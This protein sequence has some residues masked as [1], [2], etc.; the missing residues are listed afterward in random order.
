MFRPRR[1]RF[2]AAFGP[3]L[4][5]A[6]S[7]GLANSQDEKVKLANIPQALAGTW[8]VESVL[9]DLGSSRRLLYQRDD[10]RLLGN[11]FTI[12]SLK[13]VSDTPEARECLMP[14]AAEWKTTAS[15][16]VATT[17]A[18]HGI[19]GS[20]P[21]VKD[22]GLPLAPDAQVDAYSVK[23]DPGRFGPVPLG[24]ARAAIGSKDLGTWI[25]VLPS[26]DL[27]VRWYDQT[28]LLLRRGQ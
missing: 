18:P 15:S 11:Q 3:L 12:S 24:A 21:T 2:L 13:I 10:P 20:L 4:F 7:V 14:K 9:V 27:A 19:P 25:V 23:C 28:I 5:L 26:G 1:R 22:Y 6:A 17:L 16:L 8:K